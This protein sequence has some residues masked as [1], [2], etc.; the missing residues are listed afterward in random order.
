[1]ATPKTEKTKKPMITLAPAELL[2]LTYRAASDIHV[3][4]IRDSSLPLYFIFLKRAAVVEQKRE[5]IPKLSYT[6]PSGLPVL[7]NDEIGQM[8]NSGDIAE[9]VSYRVLQNILDKVIEI[10]PVGHD[11]DVS[12]HFL[13][14]KGVYESDRLKKKCLTSLNL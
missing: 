7:D 14:P 1:M 3:Y 12:H 5:W 4:S 10:Q 8:K 2:L 11:A 6:Y 9:E 13:T